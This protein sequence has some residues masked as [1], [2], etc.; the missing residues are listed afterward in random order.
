MPQEEFVEGCV[1]L[2]LP[3]KWKFMYLKKYIIRKTS[4]QIF[5]RLQHASILIK[6]CNDLLNDH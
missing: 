3:T 1:S 4:C 6:V 5:Q 2:Q